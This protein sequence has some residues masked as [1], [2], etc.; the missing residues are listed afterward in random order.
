MKILNATEMYILKWLGWSILNVFYHNLKE[1]E[2]KMGLF[3]TFSSASKTEL[4]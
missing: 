3:S 2:K 1:K 4:G